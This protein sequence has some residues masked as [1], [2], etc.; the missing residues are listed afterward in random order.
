ME[1]LPFNKPLLQEAMA[2]TPGTQGAQTGNL[3]G[4]KKM[5]E[6]E[7]GKVAGDFEAMFLAQMLSPMWEGIETD[8]MFGGGSAEETFRSMMINEY[9]KLIS[10]AGGLGFATTVK[11]ELLRAQEHS[12][13]AESPAA[14][15]A[16][17]PLS[18]GE[19]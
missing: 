8:G 11:A 16:A 13:S 1:D 9:G 4:A 18:P 12:S 2:K 7:A 10:K 6:A 15:T 5:T 14:D 19:S 17:A 3:R